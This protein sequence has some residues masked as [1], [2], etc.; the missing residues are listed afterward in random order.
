ML[1]FIANIFSSKNDRILKRMMSYVDLSNKLEDSISKK[2]DSFFKEVKTDLLNTYKENNKDIY[3][4]LPLAFALVRE[5]SKRTIG[6]RHFDSQLLGG[7]SL[8]EGNIAE[9]K[10]GEGKTLVATLP[11]YLNSV[12]GNKAI[13]VTVNDYLAR[14]DAEWM[15]PIY[16]FLGLT[17]GIVNANQQTT[18]KI[19]A[20]KCDV[21]YATNN[22]LG[23]DYLRDNMAR[24]VDE[25]V[26]CSLDFAIVDE[27][28]SILIDEAR[29]PLIISGPSSESSDL[30]QKIKKFIPKLK[31]QER[32]GTEDEP[33]SENEKGHYLI[34]EKNRN[35]ELTDDGYVLVEELLEEANV[36]GDSGGLYSVSNLKIMKFVQATL[37]ANFL[38]QKNVHYLVRK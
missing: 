35:I 29:T 22:E 37:R 27:V 9:M 6:L 18:E 38:F 2:P 16:E 20:Y 28:D 13:I 3:S 17:V 32:E 12:I 7:I 30:Y 26:Q 14:R 23:F 34:D 36:L 19:Y 4:I 10:T 25:R 31:K 11:V 15:R 8:A 21:I 5:A 33:L 24:S 1:N